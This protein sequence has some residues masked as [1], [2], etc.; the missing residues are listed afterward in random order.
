MFAHF[1]N[2]VWLYRLKWLTYIL[3]QGKLQDSFTMK[4]A[5]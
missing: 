5:T 3:M 1:T 4:K 2:Y